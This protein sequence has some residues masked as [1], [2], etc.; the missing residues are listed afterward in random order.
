[1]IERA[2]GQLAESIRAALDGTEYTPV[3]LIGRGGMGEVYEVVHDFLG[4]RF[5]LKVLH[6]FLGGDAQFA[7][8]VRVEAQLMARVRHPGVVEVIDLWVASDGRPCLLME[9]LQ[10]R[11]L[12]AVLRERSRLPAAEATRVAID[13]LSVLRAT[14]ALGI[15][16]RDIKPENIFFHERAGDKMLKVL[17]FGIAR[18][19][20]YVAPDTA[21][22][23]AIP[24][25]AGALVGSP[26]FMSPEAAAGK[27]VDTRADLYSLGLVLYVAL[28]GRGPFDRNETT[29]LAPSQCPGSDIPAALDSVVLRAIAEHIE[30]RYQTADEFAADLRPFTRPSLFSRFH[31]PEET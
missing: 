3:Q 23:L 10:G 29:P 8:R 5:A 9:L 1:M 19:V 20:A 30:D 22:R 31:N 17:D 28:T 2:P 12:A 15:V 26:R 11:T 4:K 25:Q 13:T 7:D 16:H 21:P 14:H 6:G 24:T 27:Q 18:A